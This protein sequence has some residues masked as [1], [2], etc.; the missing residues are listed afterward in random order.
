MQSDVMLLFENS[1]IN[2]A[3][4]KKSKVKK[5]FKVRRA[6]K[7]IKTTFLKQFLHKKLNSQFVFDYKVLA[8]ALS[9][10]LFGFPAPLM[11]PPD[12]AT[13]RILVPKYK[14]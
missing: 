9:E 13:K 1:L 8:E 11:E 3:I 5:N 7:E 6:T 2:S 12:V 4:K 10:C 14:I